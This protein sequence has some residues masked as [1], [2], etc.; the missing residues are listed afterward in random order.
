MPA[1]TDKADPGGQ[2]L[3]TFM[4]FIEDKSHLFLLQAIY[5]MYTAEKTH[6]FQPREAQCV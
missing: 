5:N 2:F 3:N 6:L 1:A 4:F